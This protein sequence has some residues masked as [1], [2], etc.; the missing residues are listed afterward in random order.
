MEKTIR[1][2]LQESYVEGYKDARSAIASEIEKV[3]IF[4]PHIGINGEEI[5]DVAEIMNDL[6]T[7]FSIIAKGEIK[8]KSKT[9]YFCQGEGLLQ[10]GEDCPCIK[11]S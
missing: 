5:T 6:R 7:R 1:I 8:V 2:M 11:G 9:C 3:T 4:I 10:S